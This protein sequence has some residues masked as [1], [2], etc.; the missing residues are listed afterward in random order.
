M[1]VISGKSEQLFSTAAIIQHEMMIMV[2]FNGYY[3]EDL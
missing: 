3:K 2:M 1:T